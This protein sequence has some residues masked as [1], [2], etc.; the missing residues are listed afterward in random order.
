METEKEI[1]RPVKS[2][3][4]LYEVSNLGRVRSLL[5]AGRIRSPQPNHKGYLKVGLRKNGHLYMRRVSRLVAEAFVPNPD[6]KPHVNHI[7]EDKTDNRACNLNWMTAEENNNWG[8]HNLR[9][10]L[11]NKGK[12]K[13]RTKAHSK[14]LAESRKGRHWFTNGIT[15]IVAFD[16]PSGFHKGQTRTRLNPLVHDLALIGDSKRGES[17]A[18]TTSNEINI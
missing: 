2:F 14:K 4:G 13:R 1:W 12:K 8:S 5:C 9:V 10:S 16:C 18:P 3:E 11:S 17:H 15:N 7:N 6:H